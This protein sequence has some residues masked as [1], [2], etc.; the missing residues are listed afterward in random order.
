MNRPEPVLDVV[1]S[2][3]LVVFAVAISGSVL[4]GMLLVLWKVIASWL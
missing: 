1:L 4:V 2:I 3:L